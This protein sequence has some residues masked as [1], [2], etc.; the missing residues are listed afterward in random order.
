MDHFCVMKADRDIHFYQCVEA[1][2]QTCSRY[3]AGAIAPRF[4]VPAVFYTEEL[5]D[6]G[7]TYRFGL[8]QRL[9]NNIMRLVGDWPPMPAF[10]D[11]P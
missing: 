9:P 2:C 3:Q 11:C 8:F 1:Q 5:V 6:D 7:E 4:P 10:D